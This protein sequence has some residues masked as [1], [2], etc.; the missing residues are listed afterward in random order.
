[1]HGSSLA[2]GVATLRPARPPQRVWD[3]P[4]PPAALPP[5][6]C[7]LLVCWCPSDLQKQ[8]AAASWRPPRLPAAGPALHRAG[9][10]AGTLAAGA[11]TAR[12][13]YHLTERALAERGPYGPPGGRERGPAP[14]WAALLGGWLNCAGG[15]NAAALLKQDGCPEE[16]RQVST[17]IPFSTGVQPPL[18]S[19]A[20]AQ[21][22][23]QRRTFPF[24]SSDLSALRRCHLESCGGALDSA[25]GC[26]GSL[27]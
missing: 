2:L 1:M 3:G 4:L 23:T 11:V 8:M 14:L 17:W 16:L 9:R 15:V 22:H 7:R 26:R 13:A 21:P 19:L 18:R 6:S 5:L 25:W 12:A 20:V 24:C 10:L 27:Q